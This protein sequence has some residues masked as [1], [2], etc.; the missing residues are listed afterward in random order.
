MATDSRTV[1]GTPVAQ[2]PT[3]SEHPLFIQ[4][5]P[6]VFAFL[7]STGFIGARYGVAYAEPFTFL[8]LRWI[9]AGSVI[10]GFAFAM[11]SAWPESWRQ[12]GQIAI[13][14]LLLH[15]GYL[16]GVFFAIDRGMPAG[17]S[18]LIIGMQPILTA[19][20]AQALLRENIDSR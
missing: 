4:L 3:A 5:A 9:I 6:F 2:S 15:A 8:A 10:A 16:G 14:G 7:W 20:I 13:S 12:T 1:G 11:R 19:V 18:S 17:V